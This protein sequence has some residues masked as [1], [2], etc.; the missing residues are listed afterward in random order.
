[1]LVFAA[2]AALMKSVAPG[3]EPACG[4]VG[5]RAAFA[6]EASQ[7][8]SLDFFEFEGAPL[9]TWA[10]PV[11]LGSLQLSSAE[12]PPITTEPAA[13]KQARNRLRVFG[14]I[15]KTM[16]HNA[17]D[18]IS[19]GAHTRLT[20]EIPNGLNRGERRCRNQTT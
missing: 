16:R 3:K 6:T 20:A 19:N 11:A 14:L 1:M 5:A 7:I 12:R 2:A 4:C 13:Y 17:L 15:D 9:G 18:S 8:G 10:R